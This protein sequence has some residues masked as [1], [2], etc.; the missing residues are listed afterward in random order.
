MPQ[1]KDYAGLDKQYL[2]HPFTPMKQWLAGEPI[3]IERAEGF[4]LI[5]TAGRRYIDGFSSMWCNL[6]GHRV[7][8]LDRAI[9]SQMRK[10]AHTTLLGLASIPS[11]ELARKL[12]DL[13]AELPA[14]SPETAL[15]RAFFSDSG[16]SAVEIAL[17]MAFQYWQIMGQA[18]RRRFIALK[19]G[20]HGD[21]LG[22]V[23]VGGI[24]LFGRTFRPL[25]FE[26]IF[27][28]SPN[29]FYHPRGIAA[30]K[31]V[32]GEIDRALS[33]GRGEY[34]AVVVE[35]LI[36]AAAGMLT[37]ARG[38]LKS[39]R[40]LT[41]R[42]DV[43]LIADEV[44][45]GFCR[46]GAMFACSHEGVCP[47]LMCLGKGL[48]GGYLPV[49][50]TL[51][52]QEIFDAFCGDRAEGGYG[53]TTF[54]HGHT[55]TGNALG[56]A[57]AGASIDL[58]ARSRLLES[59]PGKIDLI[60]GRLSSLSDHEHVGDIRQCGMMVGIDIVAD[61]LARKFYDPNLRVGSAIC[62]RALA[63]GIM[64][65]PLGDVIVLMPAPAMDMT[66]LTR[67]LEGTIEA[68]NEYFKKH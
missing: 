26:T 23:S 30:G 52:S 51:A 35:P 11:I 19:E 8:Q 49:A 58:I 1:K 27:V 48:T 13:A 45:T 55:F 57:A 61:R 56:C 67:L 40:E 59:L 9:R 41:R 18:R 10:A 42:H 38:F 65:R 62:E 39:L 63:A 37:H 36:Q 24:D 25:L 4:E 32:L 46:T 3:V 31:S 2:W 54:F 64:I 6:H 66:T 16:A 50:A 20:Y 5:D 60:A 17:K 44:A 14:D 47:D 15:A 29:A 12:V 68:I 34:C 22:A 43:L 53:G 7:P 21:T 28:E 33:V